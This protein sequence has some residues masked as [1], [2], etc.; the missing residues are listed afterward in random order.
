MLIDWV[1]AVAFGAEKRL[2]WSTNATEIMQNLVRNVMN[3]GIIIVG[4]LE[5]VRLR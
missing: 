5:P 2:Q 4:Q 3:D 1:Q